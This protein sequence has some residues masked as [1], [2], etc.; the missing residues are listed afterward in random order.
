MATLYDLPIIDAPDQTFTCSLNDKRCQFRVVFNETSNR[1][2]FDLWINDILVLTGRRIV[3][4][5]DLVRAFAFDIGAV[6]AFSWGA[7]GIAPDRVNLPAGRVKLIQ[8]QGTG[9]LV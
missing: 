6:F 7:E 3:T 2:S 8:V 4:G 5:V 1:W 9:P